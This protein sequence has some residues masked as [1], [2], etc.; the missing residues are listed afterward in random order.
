MIDA[1]AWAV[2]TPPG[3]AAPPAV[4]GALLLS[5]LA[6]GWVAWRAIWAQGPTP[7][8]RDDVDAHAR[9]VVDA[10]RSRGWSD[11]AIRRD[12]LSR[13]GAR[14]AAAVERALT[15]ARQDGDSA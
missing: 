9:L 5:G 6:M 11:A 2:S 3:W 7:G 4:V 13:G 15:T 12:L 10:L 1:I 8:E 14:W